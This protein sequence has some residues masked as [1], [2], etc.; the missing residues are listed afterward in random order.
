MPPS[1]MSGGPSCNRRRSSA[2]RRPTASLRRRCRDSRFRGRGRCSAYRGKI[3][4]DEALETIDGF[5]KKFEKITPLGFRPES[6]EQ[7]GHGTYL[8]FAVRWEGVL[9]KSGEKE[10][11]E[12]LGVI[13]FVDRNGLWLVQGV[14][15][16]GFKF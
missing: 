11:H 7:P 10:R 6:L 5:R 9:A 16:P 1:E 15:M 4:R 8:M 3:T 14:S 12:G 2:L 13:Q